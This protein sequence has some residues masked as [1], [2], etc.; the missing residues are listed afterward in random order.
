MG[1]LDVYSLDDIS[2]IVIL[3]G[4]MS[5]YLSQEIEVSIENITPYIYSYNIFK[6]KCRKLFLI[7]RPAGDP[8]ERRFNSWNLIPVDPEIFLT[9]SK[10]IDSQTMWQDPILSQWE[11]KA[12]REKL[13]RLKLKY[14]W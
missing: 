6:K 3:T 5:S 7:F 9:I 4:P 10:P 8:V 2:L 13:A 14:Q 11:G 1:Q 12:G